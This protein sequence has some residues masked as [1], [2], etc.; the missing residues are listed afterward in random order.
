MES[1]AKS[2]FD[3]EMTEV[4]GRSIAALLNPRPAVLVTCCDANQKPNVLSIAWHTPLSHNPPMVGISID[5]QRYSHRLIDTTNQFAINV[6]DQ[7]FYEAVEVC[8]N[9]SGRDGD[10]FAKAGLTLM[11]AHTIKPP[12]IAG[13]MAHIECVVENKVQVGSHTFFIG[14]VRYA[15]ACK[16]IFTDSWASSDRRVMLCLQ[17]DRFVT[18]A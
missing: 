10:K 4:S 13:A 2:V 5:A 7:A 9:L 17:R 18:W 3:E 16:D 6:V 8:G 1:E 11:P 12:L 14:V 15:E